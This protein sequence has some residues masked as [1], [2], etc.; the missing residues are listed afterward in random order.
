MQAI[1]TWTHKLHRHHPAMT[2]N[3]GYFATLCGQVV[4]GHDRWLDPKAMTFLA[5]TQ[6]SYKL[7]RRC[8]ARED[9]QEMARGIDPINE[10]PLAFKRAYKAG[11][12]AYRAVRSILCCSQDVDA[13]LDGEW[14]TGHKLPNG[15]YPDQHELVRIHTKDC[16]TCGVQ[17]S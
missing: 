1:A 6:R 2:A 15:H 10:P 3:G 14:S 7:C 4:T 13:T 9:I 11:D 16:P 5:K 17:G 12:L 8:F